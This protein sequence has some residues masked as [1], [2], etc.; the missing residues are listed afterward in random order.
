V[1]F[2]HSNTDNV[3]LSRISE[4]DEKAFNLLF[5]S[6]R[7]QLYNYLFKTTKSKETAEEATLDVFL[8]IWNAR[9]MLHEIQNFEAFLFRVMHNKS[10]DY[11]R[12]AKTSPLIQSEIWADLEKMASTSRADEKLLTTDIENAINTAIYNLAPQRKEAFRLSR[13]EYLSYDEIAERMK[14]SRNTVRNHV[15]AALKFI[16]DHLDN[17][18]EIAT[19]II[20]TLKNY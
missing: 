18:P 9:H 7:N 14:I 1:N 3:L 12:R 2:H 5:E 16:R 17:G 4:G 13:E 6:Y 20:L 15:S 8:K 11:L 19:I 10:L